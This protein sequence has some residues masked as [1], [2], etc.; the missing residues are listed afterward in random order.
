MIHNFLIIAWRNILRNKSFSIINIAGLSIGMAAAML[1]LTWIQHELSYDEFHEKKDR[2]YEV[3]NRYSNDGR[4]GCW[5]N[6][7]KP[8][9]MALQQDYPEVAQVTR[10]YFIP[11]V[12][13]SYKDKRISGRGKAVDS[14][15]IKMFSFPLAAGNIHTALNGAYSIVLSQTLAT[16]VFGNENPIGKVV[17]VDNSD[18]F[19]V[20]AVMQDAPANSK[21]QFDFLLPWAYMRQ[22]GMSNDAWGNNDLHTYVLLKPGVSVN[23]LQARLKTLRKK[24]DKDDPRIETFLYPL[25][26]MH[27]HGNFENGVETGGRIEIVRLFGIIAG[28]ILLIA[29]I[30]FMN[31]STARS[32]KRAREVGIRKV[33]GARKSWLIGQFL[34]E[35]ILLAFIAG[36][37]ALLIVQVTLPF[38]S[39]LI[40]QQ[41]IL[42]YNQPFIWLSAACFVLVTGILAGSYPAVYLSSF[43]PVLVLKGKIKA[44]SALLTPRKILVVMQFA[45]AIML[46]VSTIVVRQQIQKAQN[47]QAGY[48]K[49]NLVY[50]FMEGDVQKN[51]T[52]IKNELLAS[53]V[54]VSVT[55]TSAPITEGWSNTW[56]L[57]WQGKSPKDKTTIDR[58]CA[59]DAFVKTAGLQLAQGRDFNLAKYPTDSLG[60]IINESAA[61]VMGFKQPIGQLIQDMGKDWH[62]IGVIKDFI[63][64]SPYHATAPMFIAGAGGYFNVIHIKLSAARP[65][66]QN[67]DFLKKLFKKYNP[68]Y[69]FNYRFADDEY[70]SKFHDEERTGTLA[71]LFASLA[72]F[73]SCLGLFG[74][75]SY[76]AENR[77]KEIGIRKVLG[78]S[79]QNITLLLSKDFLQLVL[80]AIVIASPAA[81]WAMSKWLQNFEYRTA[82]HWWVFVIAGI[83]A[84]LI[85]LLTV[86]F[87]AV[88]AAVTNPVK[89]LRN[90]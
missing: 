52:L 76:M 16:K 59:D 15:F 86:S 90:E 58:F 56:S 42:Q 24:Y 41:L 6:T 50:H 63:L 62:V 61:K 66:Q 36:L 8:M 47:R 51:Y 14:S 30:N 40:G 68:E 4:T 73:I 17:K 28:I 20:T 81:Y 83:A 72:I 23:A 70:A 44:G 38:F 71:T 5:N 2:L 12:L 46:I 82:L 69:E 77:I 19:T 39:K 25:T 45:L 85:A 60:A 43:K 53:G 65:M 7:P 21:F 74:L 32:E 67:I 57:G 88:K 79:A 89:S 26:R 29:C 35:S 10:D 48:S 3:W 22:S 9:A 1:I 34:G 80:V 27:L 84:L 87:Q 75:S 11:P 13:F 31:L 37:F 49:D 55:K 54:A 78:A 33:V 64:Q 18:N